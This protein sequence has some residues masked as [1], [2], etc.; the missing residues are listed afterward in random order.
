MPIFLLTSVVNPSH[1]ISRNLDQSQVR[2]NGES[3]MR[4]Y[5]EVMTV[6]EL[7]DVVTFLETK[8]ELVDPPRSF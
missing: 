1:R 6:S 2:K 7:I 4:N 3:T 5:N 8:Y